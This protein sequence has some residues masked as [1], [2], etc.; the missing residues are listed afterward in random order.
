MYEAYKRVKS[1]MTT[2]DDFIGLFSFG[3]FIKYKGNA[4]LSK[5]A[6]F[7]NRETYV[8]VVTAL[9]M[10]SIIVTLIGSIYLRKKLI[11]KAI[12]MDITATTPSDFTLIGFCPQFDE[13]CD[14]SKESIEK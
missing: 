13:G 6:I 1:Q 2:R 12:D 14:Y 3:V 11:Q 4:A 9:M 7:E 10:I 5:H 8:E